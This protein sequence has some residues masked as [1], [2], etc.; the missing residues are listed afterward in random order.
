MGL[1]C[2]QLRLAGDEN[3]SS[4]PTGMCLQGYD[5]LG[6]RWALA[7]AGDVSRFLLV[8]GKIEDE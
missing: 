4:S 8:A 5:G 3:W 6:N 7:W 1:V 2:V